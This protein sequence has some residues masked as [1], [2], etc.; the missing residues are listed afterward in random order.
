[1][2][3]LDT[4]SE[5]CRRIA[6]ELKSMDPDGALSSL[7]RDLDALRS[8][9]SDTTS[10]Q[11][12]VNSYISVQTFDAE[13]A[14][15]TSDERRRAAELPLRMWANNLDQLCTRILRS[16]SSC[17][18]PVKPQV[19]HLSYA[20]AH[21]ARIV[22]GLSRGWAGLSWSGSIA[23]VSA[24]DVTSI[25][26][27]AASSRNAPHIRGRC[28]V[29]PYWYASH[30]ECLLYPLWS[31][32]ANDN[33]LVYEY[34]AIE[35]ETPS[36]AIKCYALQITYDGALWRQELLFEMPDQHTAVTADSIGFRPGEFV[37]SGWHPTEGGVGS[38][39]FRE[40]LGYKIIK[41]GFDYG[42]FYVGGQNYVG[43]ADLAGVRNVDDLS[44]Y[45][46]LTNLII[47]LREH[48]TRD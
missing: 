26:D 28:L 17:E 18:L 33:R 14:D 40:G 31:A 35:R 27:L 25:V 23:D 30:A 15:T 47:A 24:K 45:D 29:Q 12:Y 1:M 19:I 37:T 8:A 10:L 46:R 16:Q 44:I 21:L 42:L 39:T 32:Q 20:G 2:K 7:G 9:V 4:I 36:T 6:S 34:I 43:S 38:F 11:D 5:Q 48:E 3:D 22:L 13:G 41:P